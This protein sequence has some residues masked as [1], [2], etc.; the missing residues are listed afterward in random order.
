VWWSVA[1]GEGAGC[2]GAGERAAAEG[3]R[4][5][6]QGALAR[7]AERGAAGNQ[8][9]ARVTGA[10]P[11]TSPDGW[12]QRQRKGDAC[13][14]WWLTCVRQLA[15]ALEAGGTSVSTALRVAELEA[16]NAAL[17]ASVRV[18]ADASPR[19]EYICRKVVHH[20]RSVPSANDAHRGTRVCQ[21]A[22]GRIPAPRP[23]LTPPP[24]AGRVQ[25]QHAEEEAKR[26]REKEAQVRT[27]HPLH[28]P[29]QRDRD[30][31]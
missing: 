18:P 25:V 21:S 16:A 20:K 3:G 7:L 12:D 10:W 6:G 19:P 14:S 28:D 9:R 5:G 11:Y 29:M 8:L 31:P 15:K 30:A 23:W 4:R 1:A 17:K 27:A 2:G 22:R 26:A 24:P 13:W